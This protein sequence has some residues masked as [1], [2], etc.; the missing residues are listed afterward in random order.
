MLKLLSCPENFS[1][2]KTAVVV[3]DFGA[4]SV[5][6]KV[7]SPITPALAELPSGCICCQLRGDLNRTI[8]KLEKE[9][10]PDLIF[11]EPSGVADPAGIISVL[12]ENPGC[13]VKV[14]SLVDG[15]RF[16][17]LFRALRPLIES[18][19]RL[20]DKIIITKADL[21]SPDILFSVKE[22]IKG[23]KPDSPILEADLKSDSGIFAVLE[24]LT[25]NV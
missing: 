15:S 19:L 21:I 3:N 5:D 8:K 22:E 24:E 25:K 10:A 13:K 12:Q 2:L 14:I 6:S 4:V 17:K 16:S 18:Q 23:I 1:G 9:F 20:A 7:L 11:I